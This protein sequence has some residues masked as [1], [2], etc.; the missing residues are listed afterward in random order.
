[1]HKVGHKCRGT[2]GSRVDWILQT[3]AGPVQ[4]REEATDLPFVDEAS[5]RQ[6][7]TIITKSS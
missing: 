5:E 3:E 1:M 7:N 6:L 2:A 4:P